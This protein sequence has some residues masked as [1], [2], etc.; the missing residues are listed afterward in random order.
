MTSPFESAPKAD[1]LADDLVA[2]MRQ[3]VFLTD[4]QYDA[5]ALWI[6]HTYALDA[7]LVTPYLHF[8]SAEPGSGKTRAL[9][10]L[11]VLLPNAWRESS[12]SDAVAFRAT[13]DSEG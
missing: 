10:V 6:M 4:P 2:Y 12:P 7:F 9:E 11:E 13:Q 5:L 3:F 1:N 8:A